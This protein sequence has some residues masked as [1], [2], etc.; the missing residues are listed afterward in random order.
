MVKN[1][2]LVQPKNLFSYKTIEEVQAAL[3]QFYEEVL[4]SMTKIIFLPLFIYKL[5]L[6][7]FSEPYR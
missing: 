3:W 5:Y 1:S 7:T 4:L 2:I 6:Y